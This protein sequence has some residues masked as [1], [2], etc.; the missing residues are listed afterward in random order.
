V[1]VTPTVSVEL[2]SWFKEA[3]PPE[4][5]GRA[6]FLLRKPLPNRLEVETSA[7]PGAGATR[8]SAFS[9]PVDDGRTF[10]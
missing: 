4:F 10:L 5:D 7:H 9:F 2:S 1:F 3:Y 8:L 6:L